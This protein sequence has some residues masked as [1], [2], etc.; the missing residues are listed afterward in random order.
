LI[1][2]GHIPVKKIAMHA[3]STGSQET[4]PAMVEEYAARFQSYGTHG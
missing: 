4:Q 3:L 2:A 1:I